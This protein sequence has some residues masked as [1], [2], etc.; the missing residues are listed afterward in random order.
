MNVSIP[1][2]PSVAMHAGIKC[3]PK[4]NRMLKHTIKKDAIKT[5]IN[6]SIKTTVPAAVICVPMQ[7][8]IQLQA[9]KR[10]KSITIVI[11]VNNKDNFLRHTKRIA[12]TICAFSSFAI[13]NAV[14]RE[15]NAPNHT[16]IINP[17]NKVA[18][19]AQIFGAISSAK[20]SA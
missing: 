12:F 17:H 5:R 2:H 14:K 8:R 20:T 9:Y 1:S 4:S 19:Q 13:R 15:I 11:G 10:A 16:T 6:N 18:P 7:P 3:T